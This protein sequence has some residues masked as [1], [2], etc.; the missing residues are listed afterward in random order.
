MRMALKKDANYDEIRD[1][2]LACG[3]GWTD[4]WRLGRGFPDGIA[5]SPAIWGEPRVAVLIEVKDGY[6]K[7]TEAEVKFHRDYQ[8]PL[9]IVHSPEEVWDVMAEYR[10]LI[11]EKGD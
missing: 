3:W 7:L 4:S 5:I 8:G 2:F 10:E 6:G 11:L 9:V 1:E